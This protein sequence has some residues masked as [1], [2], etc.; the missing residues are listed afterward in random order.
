MAKRFNPPPGWPDAPAG[1]LPQ[2]GWEPE[3]SWPAPPEGWQFVVDDQAGTTSARFTDAVKRGG[4]EIQARRMAKSQHAE[5]D[6]ETL[7]YAK[8]QPVTG[9]GGGFYRLTKTV[10]FFEKGTLTTNA[11]QVPTNQLYDIDMR[12]TLVQKSR[13][14]GDVVV[15]I[16]RDPGVEEVTLR[17]IPKA[18]EAV[19]IINRVAHEARLDFTRLSNTRHYSS[20]DTVTP[21]ESAA[22]T[23]VDPIEQLTQLGKL[24]D[25]GV[26]TND[27]FDRKKAEILSRI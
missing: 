18:R 24:R 6:P 3:P 10:L 11:Q 5:D 17:D 21:E 20:G 13:G 1:W 4:A 22:T 27:E 23:K 12:Q 2:Q 14:V 15:H 8:G 16:R 7:W 19:A 26:L 9:I 25:A